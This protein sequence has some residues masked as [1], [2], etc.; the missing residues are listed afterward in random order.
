MLD[1]KELPEPA[2]SDGYT[3]EQIDELFQGEERERFDHWMRGQTMGLADG[4]PIIY[5]SD[6]M[7][8]VY[9]RSRGIVN[10]PVVD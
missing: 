10:P 6:V 5:A 2:H 1:V 4:K 9:Y 7:R 3:S 8:Y